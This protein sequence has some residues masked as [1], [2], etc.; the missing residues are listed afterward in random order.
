LRGRARFQKAV[1][2]IDVDIG[3]AHIAAANRAD[4]G[5]PF[6]AGVY[7]GGAGLRINVCTPAI[8]AT[9]PILQM[10]ARFIT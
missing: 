2:A 9:T 6:P 3:H 8:K 1:T 5:I 4:A 10:R 7:P